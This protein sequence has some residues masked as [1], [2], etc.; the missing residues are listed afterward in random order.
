MVGALLVLGGVLF[1]QA[2]AA[3]R[4]DLELE[5]RRLVRQLNSPRLAERNSA[6]ERLLKLGP[7]VLEY[8]PASGDHMP[9]EVEQRVARLRQVLQKEVAR[10]T[11]Q[12]STVTLRGN[13]PLGEILSAMEKQTGNKITGMGGFDPHA[14]TQRLEVRFDEKPFWQAIDEVVDQANLTVYNYGPEKAVTLRPHSEGLAPRVGRAWYQGPF[15]FEAVRIE[16]ARDLRNAAQKSL[17]LTVEV[18]WEPTLV[19]ISL[20]LPMSRIEAIDEEGHL[21]PLDSPQAELEVPI[22]ADSMASE[23][24]I[25]LVL[26]PRSVKQIAQLRGVMTALLPGKIETFRFQDLEKAKDVEQRIAGVTVPLVGVRKNNELWEVR[27]RVRFDHAGEA[28]QSHRGWIFDNEVYLEGTD[29]KPI[30]WGTYETTRQTENEVGLAYMFSVEG[31]L[32]G[33][34][35]V[36]KTPGVILTAEIPYQVKDIPLP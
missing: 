8:L 24:R 12:A 19:P 15:R 21:L 18:A 32:A 29:G 26:P 23:L 11:A 20:L 10:S 17:S 30:T 6:E 16:A 3:P 28:L 25:P 34:T 27:L 1:G 33:H 31:S 36:Y 9:A 35:L 7:E 13:L 5:V 4:P 22:T 2:D 14:S